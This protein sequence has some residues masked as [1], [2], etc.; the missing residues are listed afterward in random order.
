MK[1]QTVLEDILNIRHEILS[2]RKIER[3]Q[4]IPMLTTTLEEFREILK[5]NLTEEEFRGVEDDIG[6]FWKRFCMNP[7]LAISLIK[8]GVSVKDLKLDLESAVYHKKPA[9]KLTKDDLEQMIAWQIE[10]FKHLYRKIRR[11]KPYIIP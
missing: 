6:E 5:A 1:L 7:H 2:K 8:N 3:D 9:E 11:S 4:I 10:A